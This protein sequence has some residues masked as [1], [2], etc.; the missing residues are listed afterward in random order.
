VNVWETRFGTRVDVLAAFAYVLGPI[1]GVYI[2]IRLAW[3]AQQLTNT[4]IALLLLILETHNDYV[5]FHGESSIYSVRT[6]NVHSFL[7]PQHTNLR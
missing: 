1:S 7:S 3:K 5:R 4:R 6:L 2:H